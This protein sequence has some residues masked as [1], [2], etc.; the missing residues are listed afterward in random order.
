VRRHPSAGNLA[1]VARALDDTDPADM[2]QDVI[3]QDLPTDNLPPNLTPTD[4]QAIYSCNAS[5]ISSADSGPVTENEIGGEGTD[6]VVPVLPQSGAGTRNNWLT[7]D[8]GL[9]SSSLASCVVNGSYT[10]DG[11]A[12]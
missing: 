10:Y 12:Y 9:S 6:Q 8:L 11:T 1:F 4:L 3:A 2:A 5:L 7:D